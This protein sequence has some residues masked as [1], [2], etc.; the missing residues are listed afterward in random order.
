ML[1]IQYASGLHLGRYFKTPFPPILSPIAPILLLAGNIGRP[2]Q[3]IYRDFLHYCSRS[4]K[5][6]IVVAG[7]DELYS[8]ALTQVSVE[9]RLAQCADV[10]SEF[11]N[12]HYLDR[13]S[14]V[15]EGVHI[16]GATLW[17]APKEEDYRYIFT[18]ERLLTKADIEAWHERDYAWIQETL[19]SLEEK[20]TVILTHH[21]PC[22]TFPGEHITV[23]GDMGFGFVSVPVE[24]TSPESVAD[25]ACTA[26]TAP[27][28]QMF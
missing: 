23:S 22:C 20:P 2:D 21:R 26:A 25:A 18:G 12:V 19:D 13:D 3:R 14:V 7:P 6:V 11:Q 8:T 28:S 10:I 16:L 4:W 9:R 15:C 1:R 24:I 5:H 27:A 17:S